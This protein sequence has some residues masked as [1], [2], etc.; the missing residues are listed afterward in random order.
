MIQRSEEAISVQQT[1]GT[2]NELQ[3]SEAE[4]NICVSCKAVRVSDELLE[5]FT[6]NPETKWEHL[7]PL[8]DR[9]NGFPAETILRVCGY[10]VYA[11]HV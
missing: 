6:V 11:A 8:M 7:S 2:K 3:E 1:G 10:L 9:Y 4:V 5:S